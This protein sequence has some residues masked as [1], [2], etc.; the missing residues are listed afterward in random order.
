MADRLELVPLTALGQ[1]V[2][3]CRCDFR[4]RIGTVMRFGLILTNTVAGSSR[5]AIEAGA[6]TAE[7]LG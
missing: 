5:G 1:I 6:E 4:A 2:S 7:R 3:R